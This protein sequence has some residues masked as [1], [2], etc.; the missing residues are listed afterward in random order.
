MFLCID[1]RCFLFSDVD[2][3]HVYSVLLSQSRFSFFT[4]LPIQNFAIS[5]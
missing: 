5:N 1:W 4:F 3:I 2:I